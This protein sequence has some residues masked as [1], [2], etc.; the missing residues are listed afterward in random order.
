MPR[1]VIV[2]V[3]LRCEQRAVLRAVRREAHVRRVQRHECRRA[4]GSDADS[5]ARCAGGFDTMTLTRHCLRRRRAIQNSYPLPIRRER[6]SPKLSRLYCIEVAVDAGTKGSR[7]SDHRRFLRPA[8]VRALSRTQGPRRACCARRA[9]PASP[10]R[11]YDSPYD[12]PGTRPRRAHTAS[13]DPEREC[14]TSPRQ[15]RR[16]RRPPRDT[17][18]SA[19]QRFARRKPI[20]AASSCSPR[21][22]R[23]APR[24]RMHEISRSL[25]RGCLFQRQS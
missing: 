2:L 3:L 12:P 6:S 19:L 18:R 4:A 21:S 7:R 17:K 8:R 16:P 5:P 14:A 15:A 24:V 11:R 20:E 23:R 13:A 25:R 9:R 22:L 1:I 10:A